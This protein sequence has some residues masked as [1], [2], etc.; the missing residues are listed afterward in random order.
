MIKCTLDWKCPRLSK[1]GIC[2]SECRI[3]DTCLDACYNHP[4]KCLMAREATDREIM[5]RYGGKNIQKKADFDRIMETGKPKGI[6]WYRSGY[7]NDSTYFLAIDNRA[8][9]PILSERYDTMDDLIRWIAGRLT[10][11]GKETT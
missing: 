7:G 8:G 4:D 11:A 6:F 9:N 3:N 5:A 2:C 1:S 10:Y